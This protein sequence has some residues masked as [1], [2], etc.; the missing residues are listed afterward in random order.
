M[1]KSDQKLN[2][3]YSD[4][5]IEHFSAHAP[6]NELPEDKQVTIEDFI[7]RELLAKTLRNQ[8]DGYWSGHAAYGIAVHGGFLHDTRS[9]EEK[10]LTQLGVVFLKELNKG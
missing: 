8:I 1:N 6:I 3:D 2:D 9:S 10:K 5:H 4:L 7:K